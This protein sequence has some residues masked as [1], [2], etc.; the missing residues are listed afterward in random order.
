MALRG[1]LGST[2]GWDMAPL[3]ST[4]PHTCQHNRTNTATPALPPSPQ[5]TLPR[6]TLQVFNKKVQKIYTDTNP[7][8]RRSH[9]GRSRQSTLEA[10]AGQ[11]GS[12]GSSSLASTQ[13]TLARFP[14]H[15]QGQRTVPQGCWKKRERRAPISQIWTLPTCQPHW[16]GLQEGF[17]STSTAAASVRGYSQ[18]KWSLHSAPHPF[19]FPSKRSTESRKHSLT[20]ARSGS[21]RGK[22]WELLNICGDRENTLL[23]TGQIH[24]LNFSAQEQNPN[25]PVT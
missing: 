14:H 10:G 17:A 9:G 25:L 23:T 6:Q 19:M 4:H 13:A 2:A 5:P 20:S 3:A 8:P 1:K 24:P 21:C 12:A 7:R 22:S 16:E 15:G 11:R 18:I